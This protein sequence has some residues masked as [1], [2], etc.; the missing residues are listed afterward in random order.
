MKL[1]RSKLAFAV[2]LWGWLLLI[3]WLSYDYS[4]FGGRWV[5]HLF[6]END[7]Y[8]VHAF[9]VLIFLVPF[10]YTF[11]GYLV[12]ERE[13]LL[14]RVKES[15]ENFRSLSLHDELTNLHNRRGFG[16]L[17]AQQF[18]IAERTKKKM[19]LLFVDVDNLKWIN[20]NLGHH[21]GDR[22]LIDA[23]D[24][25]RMHIRKADILARFGGDEF[26][27]VISDTSDSLPEV[28][29]GRLQESLRR[30]N[31]ETTRGYTL[32][33]SIGFARYDPASPCS[34]EEMIELADK[35]MYENKQK[36]RTANDSGEIRDTI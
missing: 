30:L 22:A 2:A 3:S 11:L 21:I 6:Q 36:K 9:H 31:Q 29:S 32:S 20:D 7:R 18:K 10:I 5:R 12:N 25:L 17:A 13:K 24:I 23:A 28:L 16:F 26:A 19:L 14:Q 34:L 15:E 4:E 1:L 35:V 27:A 33:F 8:E